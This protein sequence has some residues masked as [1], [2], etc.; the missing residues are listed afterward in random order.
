MTCL[1]WDARVLA[2][3]AL[4]GC[5]LPCC[6]LQTGILLVLLFTFIA[7]LPLRWWDTVLYDSDTVFHLLDSGVL[8][9]P[10]GILLP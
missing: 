9:W 2:S 8:F 10:S 3:P 5:V 6:L 7:I 4:T 1:R